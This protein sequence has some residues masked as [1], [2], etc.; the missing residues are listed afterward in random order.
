MTPS[1]SYRLLQ[2]ALA[3]FG[4]L[5]LLLYPLAVVWPA[6]P[7][8]APQPAPRP[9]SAHNASARSSCETAG[10]FPDFARMFG[11]NG[12]TRAKPTQFA[13]LS[14]SSSETAILIN[15]Y[16]SPQS[17]EITTNKPQPRRVID[18]WH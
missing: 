9:A 16:G 13:T 17:N 6:S 10:N 5:M 1:T 12:A 15:R 11:Q 4:T 18:T 7:A 3:F 8:L 2:I 14:G